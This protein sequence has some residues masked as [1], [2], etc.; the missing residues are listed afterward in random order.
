MN[1]RIRKWAGLA[2]SLIAAGT[3]ADELQVRAMA[4]S[5]ATCHGTGGLAQPGMASLAG[6]SHADLRQKLFDFKTG[7][8]PATLMHQ[9]AKGYSDEQ[10][11]QLA[12]YFAALN[13]EGQRP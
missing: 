3:S 4:A 12:S 2:L 8:T 10:L 13:H 6:Q 9:L 11:D 1:N 7:K 5:C